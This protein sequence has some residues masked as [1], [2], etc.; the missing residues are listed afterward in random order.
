MINVLIDD[1]KEYEKVKY[2][3]D[4]F[5][6]IL[7]YPY[8]IKGRNN[9][10]A[11]KGGLL[12]IYYG[13]NLSYLRKQKGNIIIFSSLCIDKQNLNLGK[14]KCSAFFPSKIILNSFSLLSREEELDGPLDKHS[15]FIMT[16]NL[17]D[18]ALNKN[19]SL[20]DKIIRES[21]KDMNLPL[22]KKCLWP[23]NKKFAVCLTHDVDVVYKYN[24]IGSLGIIKN[25]PSLMLNVII[26]FLKK[27]LLGYD[28]YWQFF[29]II[30]LENRYG[31]RSTFFFCPKKRHLLDPNYRIFEK[32]IKEMIKHLDGQGFEIALHSSYSSFENPK[33]LSDEKRELE[34]LVFKVSGCRT[35]FLRFK[36]P[37][38]W[39][40]HSNAGLSYS[41]SLGYSENLGHRNGLCFPFRPYDF[42]NKKIIDILEIP[43]VI[44]DGTLFDKFRTE[45]NAW[46]EVKSIIDIV[47]K[48]NGLVTF[49]WHQRV[50]NDAEF[51]NYSNIYLRILEYI[52]DKSSFVAGAGEIN[53]WWSF[54]ENLKIT[55]KENNLEF[56]LFEIF[57]PYNVN[58]FC[59]ETT[60]K[61]V[62]VG[63]SN[64]Y[65][66]IS[67]V[68]GLLIEFNNLKGSTSFE[69]KIY[70]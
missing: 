20:L 46:S 61:K 64:N 36:V 52:S 24:F 43:L 1:N 32:K 5:L 70:K 49:D 50:F 6:S 65:K 33:I 4:T 17:K 18:P 62:D 2:V 63:L 42:E 68:S 35:H 55:I 30:N 66:I 12:I 44:M 23:E 39:S 38:T 58:N 25:K 22:I 59:F 9:L 19:L 31:Y 13:N 28:P 27:N 48:N 7:G 51:N 26:G 41:A 53:K 11:D 34:N 40:N 16:G 14:D 54:R 15:R 69:I 37:D 56:F 8:S 60:S 57:V 45:E 67:L 47:R 21:Y 10:V 3:F 29:K